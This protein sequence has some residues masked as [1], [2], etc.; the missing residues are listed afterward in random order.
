MPNLN[1]NLSH[2]NCDILF[3]QTDDWTDRYKNIIISFSNISKAPKNYLEYSKN[4]L[5]PVSS[6]NF[7]AQHVADYKTH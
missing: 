4:K 6:T 1:E 2:R 3:G 5:S 7:N